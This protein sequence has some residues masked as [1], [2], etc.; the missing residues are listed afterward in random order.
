MDSAV[1]AGNADLHS[2]VSI[3]NP[4]KNPYMNCRF[5]D[6][7]R[8][9]DSPVQV[10]L[11]SPCSSQGNNLQNVPLEN[12]KTI[13]IGVLGG[14]GPEATSEFYSKLIKELQK[15]K[16]IKRNS[17]YPRIIINSIP[18]PELV[19]DKI[20][21]KDLEQ[22]IE[23]IK[24]LDRCGAD[25]IVMVCNT[26]HLY[27]EMLQKE[28]KTPILDLRNAV[29]KAIAGKKRVL[30]IGTPSTIK[31]GL[32]EFPEVKYESLTEKEMTRISGSI[33][34]FNRGKPARIADICRKHKGAQLIL[35]CTEL[36]MMLKKEKISNIS[37]L[38]IL[39]DAAADKFQSLKYDRMQN[40]TNR[41][42]YQ[43]QAKIR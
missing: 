6:T 30:V 32:Y 8:I 2:P 35:A 3:V 13:K 41:S 42:R 17:D 4:Q 37:T 26:I 20:S 36:S 34:K 28:S 15:R 16:L 43:S 40:R 38:D 11:A 10:K 24:F 33:L 5:T 39:V 21:E 14:I 19:R 12:Y 7:R 31:Q 22:Y 18:A 9:E 29:R 23:G 27:Y 25:F 1:L